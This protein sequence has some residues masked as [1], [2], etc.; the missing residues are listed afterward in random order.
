MYLSLL[1]NFPTSAEVWY[2]G[3]SV[4]SVI[5]LVLIGILGMLTLFT[6]NPGWARLSLGSRLQRGA[7][8]DTGGHAAS[9]S[10]WLGVCGLT[11][12]PLMP[13]GAGVFR[14][15]RLDIIS[16]GEYVPVETPVTIVRVEGHRMVVRRT[17]PITS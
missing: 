16:E 10:P 4:L 5:I 8:R 7:G 3:L 12:T 17:S 1:G 9:G 14:G 2:A 11:E 15:Q 6:Y 13:S